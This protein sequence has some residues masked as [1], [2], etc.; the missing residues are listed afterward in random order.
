MLCEEYLTAGKAKKSLE[1]EKKAAKE[2]LDQYTEQVFLKYQAQINSLLEQFGADFRI[3]NTTQSYVGGK[4]SS[5]Y[6]LVI[7]NVPVAL[8]G[9]DAPIDATTFRNTLSSGDRSTL[10]LAFFLAQLDLD[11][12]LARK[13]V[14]LDDPFT[15]QDRSRRTCTQQLV[16]RKSTTAAQVIVLSHDAD[17]LKLV[18]EGYD[19]ALVKTL[20]LAR[21][22][23]DTVLREWD[24]EAE[25]R[26]A[27]FHDQAKLKEFADTGQGD[28]RAVVRCIRPVL[29]GYMRLRAYPDFKQSEWLGDLIK[30]IREAAVGTPLAAFQPTLS[31]L[32]DINDFSKKYH[33]QDNPIGAD[34]EPIDDGEL[35]TYVKRTLAFVAS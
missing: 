27:Y 26:P 4:A 34:S 10:A 11:P 5:D 21:T 7:N 3:T 24:I 23:Q 31:E 15:S 6:Q 18:W 28:R 9:P 35:L 2:K 8:G 17:F 29:E 32:E 33:H 13:V 30:N 25:T 16:R 14:V 20:Q 22:G 19:A 1:S 12:D